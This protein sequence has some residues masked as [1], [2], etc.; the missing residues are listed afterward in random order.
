ML[1]RWVLAADAMNDSVAGEIPIII[2]SG[3]GNP[4]PRLTSHHSTRRI[5]V[6]VDKHS[7]RG[8]AGVVCDVSSHLEDSAL[9]LVAEAA[10]CPH[11]DLTDIVT[12]HRANG[13]DV[14]VLVN[15]DD[16]PAGVYLIPRCL[17][18]YVQREG[19]MDLKEQWLNRVIEC[20]HRVG[21]H[22][23]THGY[24]QPLRT[25]EQLLQAARTASLGHV[26]CQASIR[27]GG[28]TPTSHRDGFNCIAADAIVDDS[29]VIVD[30]IIMPGARVGASSIVTRS[31]VGHDSAV[32]TNARI[33]DAV[34]A[35]LQ[36]AD[37]QTAVN[38]IHGEHKS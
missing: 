33:V 14:T 23:M 19:Y 20:N 29:A 27:F 11:F 26:S 17:L 36:T 32:P 13:F 21:V 16:T 34:L 37:S 2:A 12:C 24:S 1:D 22:R 18:K 25:R 7:I 5:E 6:V 28:M 31:I 8:A 30:S 3:S 35:P 4:A 10:R 15:P 9:L 38:G